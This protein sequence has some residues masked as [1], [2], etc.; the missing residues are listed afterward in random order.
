[1][2]HAFRPGGPVLQDIDLEIEAG[3]FVALLGPSGC[4]KSTLL[5]FV[6]GLAAPNSGSITLSSASGAPTETKPKLAFVF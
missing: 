1:M 4:G 3:S 5:R 6:S 2:S